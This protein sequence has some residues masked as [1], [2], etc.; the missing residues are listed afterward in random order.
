MFV[1]LEKNLDKLKRKTTESTSEDDY[2]GPHAAMAQPLSPGEPL[3]AVFYGVRGLGP[4]LSFFK[5]LRELQEKRRDLDGVASDG[6]GDLPVAL[7]R[8]AAKVRIRPC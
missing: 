5:N 8:R 6:S 7:N 3:E 1:E 2:S 4:D